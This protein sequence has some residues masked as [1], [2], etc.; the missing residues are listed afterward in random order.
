MLLT[1]TPLLI[2]MSWNRLLPFN[3]S[4]FLFYLLPLESINVF[5]NP[6]PGCVEARRQRADSLPDLP[7]PAERGE[8]DAVRA[9]LLLALHPP[10]PR[11]HRRH[12]PQVPDLRPD[13][14]EGGPEVGGG[15]ASA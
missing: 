8:A 14:G 5:Q 13:G 10:L 15:G 7:L 9:R 3:Q 6:P 11:S 4:V 12:L 1:L 2:G